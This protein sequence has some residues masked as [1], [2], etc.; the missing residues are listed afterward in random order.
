MQPNDCDSEVTHEKRD[1]RKPCKKIYKKSP[2]DVELFSRAS[3]L[4]P[5]FKSLT[6]LISEEQDEPFARIVTK[7]KMI[8]I[9]A[10]AKCG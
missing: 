4:D 5:R 6:G 9:K 7:A 10:I 3:A 2:E 1:S 8:D